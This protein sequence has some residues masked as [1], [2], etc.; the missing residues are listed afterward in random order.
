MEIAALVASRAVPGL[1]WL[2][3][4]VSLVAFN[5]I[6][7][8]TW[9]GYD[10]TKESTGFTWNE[11]LNKWEFMTQQLYDYGIFF[12]API[13][14]L[15]F[16]AMYRA[17]WKLAV[18]FTL[19]FVPGVLVYTSYYWGNRFAGIAYLRFF[20]TLFPAMI[21][22]AC[23]YMRRAW[24]TTAG[25]IVGRGSIAMPLA[26]GV[27]VAISAAVGLRNMLPTLQREQANALNLDWTC[28]QLL[29]RAPPGS[30]LFADQGRGP[31]NSLLNFLQFKGDYELYASAA[32]EPNGG[33]W[34]GNGGPPGR[35]E[36]DDQPRPMQ[37]ARQKYLREVVYKDKSTDDLVHEQH[38]IVDRALDDGCRAFVL[39]PTN[40]L[41][42]FRNR[43]PTAQKYELKPVMKWKEPAAVP[44]ERTASPL[45]SQQRMPG[46]GGRGAQTWQL[47]E[48]SRK[49]A[50]ATPAKQ[51]VIA[52]AQ[53]PS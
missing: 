4:V 49:P 16:V 2:V 6:A 42:A 40:L 23:W 17:S 30:V 45:M 52:A 29:L 18:F 53:G 24:D 36:D 3:P 43:F 48:I 21:A 19:W 7:M 28:N 32:F 10:S 39:V 33:G 27:I 51:N 31:M 8:G 26:C 47:Y 5:K 14:V 50:V 22:A 1:A 35:R 13:A 46:F 12:L 37:A 20:L 9:T 15:G 38:R 41:S 25:A 11:F 34:R 44:I